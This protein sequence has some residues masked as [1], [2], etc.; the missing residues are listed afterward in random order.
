MSRNDDYTT[1]HLLDYLHH[2]NNYKLI[3]IDISTKANTNIPQ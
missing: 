3:G 1:G 2:K